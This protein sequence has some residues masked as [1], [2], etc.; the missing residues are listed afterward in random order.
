MLN[1][2]L[3]ILARDEHKDRWRYLTV[4][5]FLVKCSG[6]RIFILFVIVACSDATRVLVWDEEKF[7]IVRDNHA[8]VKEVRRAGNRDFTAVVYQRKN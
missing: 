6:S 8:Q 4:T 2:E 5:T 7:L 1:L 3:V